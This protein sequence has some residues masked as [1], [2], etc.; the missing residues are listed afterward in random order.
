MI[1]LSTPLW[2][3]KVRDWLSSMR[4]K[5][6]AL[7][8]LDGEIYKVLSSSYSFLALTAVDPPSSASRPPG[9]VRFTAGL[10]EH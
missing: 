9:N 6:V 1:T 4:N 10:T 2:N 5:H 3:W 8:R 7:P